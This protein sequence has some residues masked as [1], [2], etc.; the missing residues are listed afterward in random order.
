MVPYKDI[1]GSLYNNGLHRYVHSLFWGSKEFL[2]LNT[3]YNQA[4]DANKRYSK[5]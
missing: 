2:A 3:R 4:I 1:R 5:A